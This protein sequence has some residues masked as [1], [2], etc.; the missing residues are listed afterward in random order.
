M[1]CDVVI[2][3]KEEDV[4]KRLK[5]EFPKGVDIIY[6]SVGGNMRNICFSNLAPFGR[7][8]I[9]GSVAEDYEK[10]DNSKPSLDRYGINPMTLMGGSS[11]VSGFFLFAALS[12]PR[13]SEI[14][15]KLFKAVQTGEIK[16]NVDPK[17]AE[18]VGMDGVAKAQLYMRS[19][20]NVGKIYA[21]IS[22]LW[23]F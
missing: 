4:D 3:Y 8:I 6:E 10:R 9:I 7:L 11:S 15:Q 16:I 1:G 22:K 13:F 21:V 17:C 12:H 2:N 18:F 23:A 19:G 14:S 20:S 5:E